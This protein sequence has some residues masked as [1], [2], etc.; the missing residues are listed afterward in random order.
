MT[1]SIKQTKNVDRSIYQQG[2]KIKNICIARIKFHYVY[3]KQFCIVMY[4][5]WYNI[6][7]ISE[8]K[9]IHCFKIYLMVEGQKQ[10]TY[11]S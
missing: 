2:G 9:H 3:K 11:L 7:I 1:V 6:S 8:G 4:N 10:S 5:H